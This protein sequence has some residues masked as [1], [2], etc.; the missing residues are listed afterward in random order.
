MLPTS[1]RQR[2]YAV[3]WQIEDHAW[4]ATTDDDRTMH[5][6]VAPACGAI[7]GGTVVDDG[8][9]QLVVVIHDPSLGC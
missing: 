4:T 9:I 7:Q 8:L 1:P 6:E 5:S 2:G 3:R